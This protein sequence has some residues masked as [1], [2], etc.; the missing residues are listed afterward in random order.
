MYVLQQQKLYLPVHLQFFL[1]RN[2]KT[3]EKCS[4]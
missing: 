3:T 4:T 2:V 1:Y